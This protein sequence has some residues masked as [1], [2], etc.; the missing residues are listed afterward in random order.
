V[1]HRDI[2]PENI[3]LTTG[4]DVKLSDF[5]WSVYAPTN[6]RS[7]LC[8]TVDYLP[9][10]MIKVFSSFFPF[11]SHFTQG[12]P[13]D[14]AVDIWGLGI[15]LYELLTGRP[16]FETESIQD[17]YTNICKE[18]IVF[19]KDISPE[20]QDLIT[21][22]WRSYCYLSFQLLQKDAIKRASLED[23]LAHPFFKKYLKN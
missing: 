22:V 14:S 21:Q 9:P 2:K 12:K 7:T 18:E 23:A 19:P 10:E 13:Y 1:I 16:P 3:L 5:G 11:P 17:T 6:K 4:G 8:G 15:L 20:A